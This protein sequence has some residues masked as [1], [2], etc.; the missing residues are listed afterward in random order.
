MDII[1][2]YFYDITGLKETEEKLIEYKN[3]LKGLSRWQENLLESERTKIAGDLHDSIGQKVSVLK[4]ELQS[5]N[6]KF[7][8]NEKLNKLFES[9]DSLSREIRDICYELKP[10]F[11][12]E[13]GLY[14]ALKN[15]MN[16]I[17]D[18]TGLTGSIDLIG[19]NFRLS[20]EEELTLFRVVQECLNNLIKHSEADE[21][22]VQLINQNNTV[23]IIISD[24]GKG[25]DVNSTLASSGVHGFGLLNMIE[26]IE[27]I[28]GKISFNSEIGMG[29]VVIVEKPL[30]SK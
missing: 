30:E 11:L 29:T 3:R 9:I 17:N 28:G 14:D 6:I 22:S 8:D 7:E 16:R 27:N 20:D 5:P 26:R 2:I 12:K 23:R 15:L 24:D 13:Y 10:Q 21:F 1:N 19:E 4:M 18:G 25:F